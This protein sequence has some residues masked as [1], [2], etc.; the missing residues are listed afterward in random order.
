MICLKDTKYFVPTILQVNHDV[1]AHKL[2]QINLAIAR[3]SGDHFPCDAYF[4][5]C[6]K[7]SNNYRSQFKEIE[8]ILDH[9]T[10][11]CPLLS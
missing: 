1:T 7:I 4:I 9:S 2:F 6:V 5:P 3:I 10:R 8:L 11:I